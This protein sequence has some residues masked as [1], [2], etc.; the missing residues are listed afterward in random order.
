MQLEERVAVVTGAS[1]GIGKATA[2]RLAADGADVALLAR[3][4]ADL[5][6]VAEAIHHRGGTAAVVPVDLADRSAVERAATDICDA[7]G[8]PDIVVNSAGVGDWVSIWESKPGDVEYNTAVTAFGAYNLARQFL[9]SML[10]RNGGHFVFVESP[11][12]HAPI[13]G[14]TPYQVARYALRGLSES[15]WMDLYSTDIGVTTVIPGRVDTEYETRNENVEERLPDFGG[16]PQVIEPGRVADAVL[17]GI[18]DNKR[19]VYVP[20]RL[21]AILLARRVA[22]TRIDKRTA[23]SGWQPTRSE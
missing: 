11:T 3:T 19:R 14:A 2:K 15:L 21:R 17:T 6:A 8:T 10:E 20:R 12:A 9:P 13:P 7:V 5:T 4:E 1:S 23:N 18:R 16:G 22:P